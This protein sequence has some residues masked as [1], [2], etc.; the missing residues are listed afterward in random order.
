MKF[1]EKYFLNPWS[2]FTNYEGRTSR[3]VYWTFLLLN[4]L[5]IVVFCYAS[6]SQLFQNG[7]VQELFREF[8]SFF[9]EEGLSEGWSTASIATTAKTFFAVAI[10]G[11]LI[12]LLLFSPLLFV[13]LLLFVMVPAFFGDNIVSM[14][15]FT[16]FMVAFSAPYLAATIRRFHDMGHSGWLF[17][18]QLV[19]VIGNIAFVVLLLMP[20]QQQQNQWGDMPD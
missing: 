7:V 2:D 17:F 8:S 1:L 19:P 15:L 9:V 12:A 14:Q 16:L 6:L 4:M 13:A 11:V 3:G 10:S 18:V 5:C 20:S